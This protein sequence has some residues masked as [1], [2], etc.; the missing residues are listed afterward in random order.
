M[1][2]TIWNGFFKN[3]QTC[4]KPAPSVL[5]WEQR[6]WQTPELEKTW[7]ELNQDQ[8]V[9][10]C[11]L[12]LSPM[13][14]IFKNAF[15]VVLCF[16]SS[17]KVPTDERFHTSSKT[18]KYYSYKIDNKKPKDFFLVIKN[19]IHWQMLLIKVHLELCSHIGMVAAP[20][21]HHVCFLLSWA[22]FTA[23]IVGHER[24]ALFTPSGPYSA[25]PNLSSRGVWNTI[26]EVD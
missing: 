15:L 10:T 18:R 17:A 4:A 2:T 3:I 21:H 7:S 5:A 25:A 22:V 9:Q 19:K 11:C 20:G 24:S 8:L 16:Q 13:C 6:S 23:A 1:I 14:V 12:Q 26:E